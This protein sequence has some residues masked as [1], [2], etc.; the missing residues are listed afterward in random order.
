VLIFNKIEYVKYDVHSFFWRSLI[1]RKCA[2]YFFK[3]CENA[4]AWRCASYAPTKLF[5]HADVL[6][7]P[8]EIFPCFGGA[9]FTSCNKF[10][11]FHKKDAFCTFQRIFHLWGG[12]GLFCIPLTNFVFHRWTCFTCSNKLFVSSR[13]MCSVHCKKNFCLWWIHLLHVPTNF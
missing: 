9:G 8:W 10:V 1:G 5:W 6:C 4:S 7:V 3:Y 13:G 2:L 12:R 11:I